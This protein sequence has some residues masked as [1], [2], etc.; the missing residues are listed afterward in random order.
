MRRIDHQVTIRMHGAS[1]RSD[2]DRAG[3]YQDQSG[4][5]LPKVD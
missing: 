1:G 4:L 3:K 5:T 2:A